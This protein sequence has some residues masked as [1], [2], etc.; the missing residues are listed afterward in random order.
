MDFLALAEHC[1][2]SVHPTTMAAVA[3]VESGFNPYAIG[4]VGGR[5]VRQP[6]GRDEAIATA[7]ALEQQGY[8]F[9]L[10]VGQ[11]NRHNLARYGLDYGT[12][13]DA[14]RNLGAGASILSDCYTRATKVVRTEQGALQ[15]A[16]SCYYSGN[17][18]TGFR[19][20]YVSK[21]V[22][23]RNQVP[24]IAASPI[25]VVQAT[26]GRRAPHRVGAARTQ[27]SPSTPLVPAEV[28]SALLF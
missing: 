22:G 7:K 2:P 11:V 3:R 15:A 16:L 5:L 18:T 6:T 26:S 13:F 19:D 1:A 8:N 17:F 14:C 28:Q 25:P 4:V 27:P 9:S 24:S 10:G 20:G 12:A 23:N 21:V